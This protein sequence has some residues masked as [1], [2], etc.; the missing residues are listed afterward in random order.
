[1]NSDAANAN[2]AAQHPLPRSDGMSLRVKI[3]L[4]FSGLTVL[5]FA[6]LMAVEVAGT[7]ASVR[8]EMEA[9]SR[10]A[11]Q[12]LGRISHFYARNMMPELV[13]FLRDTG[14][15]RANDIRL[16]DTNGELLYQSPPSLY[17]AGRDA[18]AWYA[19]LVR[20]PPTERSIDLDG[21]RLVLTAN[22][23]RAIL[24]GWDNLFDI[25]FSQFLLLLLA[26]LVL[27]WL[28]GR[29]LA[30]LERIERGLREIEQGDHQVRLPPLQGKEAGEMGRA[31]NRMAQAVEDNIQVRQASAEAQARLDAQREFTMLLHARIEEERAAIARELHDELG[32]SLTAIRS[33]AKS[34]MQHPDVVGGPL[35][36]HAK[37]L[38]DTAG[39][40]SDAMRRLIPRLR[41]I[42][43]EG[44]G[45][46]DA[47][48]DLLTETQQNHSEVRFELSVEREGLPALDDQLEL[49]A[50]R[51]VQEAVTNVVR[52]SGAS[53]A[54]VVIG[55]EGSTLKI[56]IADNGKG[57]ETLQREGHYGVRGMQERAAAFGGDI[58][59][60]RGADGGLA[61]RVTLPLTLGHEG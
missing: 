44:M 41:P 23:T 49:T 51:I 26:D 32:Q 2:F 55:V 60:G 21:A 13:A 1:M 22:P 19:A 33:I 37:M 4:I 8:E 3:N 6:V 50:Y 47:I 57:A 7:R 42:Q 54:M 14:R 10:I 16:Y 36:R 39:M 31:F 61:V 59:F 15:V 11:S 53:R 58:V 48:R 52:H 34:M 40:T 12:L 46:V 43:L 56:T 5:I 17:K 38:F 9:S 28:V 29:W 30:P 18:P 27:F 45:L 35:E 24:D 25:L 20:P